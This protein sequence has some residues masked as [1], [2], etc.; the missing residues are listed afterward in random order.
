M[1]VCQTGLYALITAAF[2]HFGIL[3]SDLSLFALSHSPP[4]NNKESTDADTQSI[5]WRRPARSITH[6]PLHTSVSC[7]DARR[8]GIINSMATEAQNHIHSDCHRLL[9]SAFGEFMMS[10]VIVENSLLCCFT[11]RSRR[12]LIA[13]GGS[14]LAFC[15][16][17]SRT[18]FSTVDKAVQSRQVRKGSRRITRR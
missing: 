8:G 11:R 3:L 9:L 12:V 15:S 18:H 6:L 17:R 16:E 4:Q 2:L 5:A 1:A 7:G 13:S 14:R 10:V